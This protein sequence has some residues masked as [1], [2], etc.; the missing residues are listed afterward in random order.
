MYNP[1]WVL[2]FVC[3]LLGESGVECTNLAM[4]CWILLQSPLP[5][6]KFIDYNWLIAAWE[7]DDYE[8]LLGGCCIAMPPVDALRLRVALMQSMGVKCRLAHIVRWMRLHPLLCKA[9][10]KK[11]K[12]ARLCKQPCKKFKSRLARGS[13]VCFFSVVPPGLIVA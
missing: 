8:E 6:V 2:I 5:D 12:S 9:P 11:R 3:R 10:V 7:I 13:C 1:L 4:H